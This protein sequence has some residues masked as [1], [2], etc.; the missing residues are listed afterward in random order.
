MLLRFV[1]T[2]LCVF[3]VSTSARAD[4]AP[5]LGVGD[6]IPAAF[7]A[8]DQFGVER[9]FDDL[10]GENGLVLVF[11]RSADWCPYCQAQLIDLGQR[12]HEIENLGYELAILSYDSVETLMEF[13]KEYD[14]QYTLLSD[15][16]SGM[17]KDFGIL[18]ESIDTES[19][20]YG[21][22]HPGIFVIGKNGVIGGKLFEE[23][24]KNRPPVDQITATLESLRKQ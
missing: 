4:S 6:E 15:P 2:I 22:P 23:G 10:T 24:Y 14:F 8:T 16:D 3:V 11:I 18:N 12:G 17:I 19:S 20:Y 7:A 1:L 21:I 13:T 9:H 5:G